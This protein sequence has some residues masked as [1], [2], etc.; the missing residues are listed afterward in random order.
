MC[1]LAIQKNSDNHRFLVNYGLIIYNG[2]T[3]DVVNFWI[4]KYKK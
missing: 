3:G 2:I 4:W 1:A